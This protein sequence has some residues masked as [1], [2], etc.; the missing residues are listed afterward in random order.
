MFDNL[1]RHTLIRTKNGG[2][3]LIKCKIY[4]WHSMKEVPCYL[5]HLYNDNTR[6][7]YEPWTCYIND[8]DSVLED[9]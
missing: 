6:V 5:G 2:I 3:F 9:I 7:D 4:E 8:I 1:P